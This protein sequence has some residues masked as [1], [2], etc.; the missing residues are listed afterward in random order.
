MG[1]LSTFP[2]PKITYKYDIDW[3]PVWWRLQNPV[4][5]MSSRDIMFMVIHNIV[6]NKERVHGFHMIA[7]PNCSTCGVVEDNVHLFCECSSVR[8]AW[9][10]LGQRLLDLLQAEARIT[11]NFEFLHLM[12][13][14][15]PFETE[16]VWLL[17]VHVNLVWEI[18][19]CKK[20][21]VNQNLIKTKYLN[22]HFSNKPILNHIVGLFA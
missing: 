13:E 8:E 5:D 7:S 20:K 15:S 10:W 21:N 11:S 22:Q 12:F 6:A 18:K 3:N 17:G 14:S 19:V 2:P 4:L 1:F 9:F 16:V